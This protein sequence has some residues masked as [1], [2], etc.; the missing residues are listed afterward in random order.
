MAL[1]GGP[2]PRRN[3]AGGFRLGEIHTVARDQHA[4]DFGRECGVEA[5]VAE[6]VE[7]FRP[8]WRGD[9]HRDIGCEVL[10]RLALRQRVAALVIDDE[11]R[12]REVDRPRDVTLGWLQ[13]DGVDACPHERRLPS[14]VTACSLGG[15]VAG[16]FWRGHSGDSQLVVL[17]VRDATERLEL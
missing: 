6:G 17:R 5:V 16:G 15:A 3:R 11:R 4:P 1:S 9:P 7:P 14:A 8:N 12:H 13:R 2:E 10:E